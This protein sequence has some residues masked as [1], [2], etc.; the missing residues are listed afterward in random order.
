LTEL[1]TIWSSAQ[2]DQEDI[3]LNA[4]FAGVDGPSLLCGLVKPVSFEELLA[5]LPP[6]PALDRL[7]Q[8][9]FNVNGPMTPTFRKSG[10][11]EADF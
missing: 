11:L 6:K 1:K 8:R 5:T 3:D 9:F 4:S 10:I 2:Q 7:L